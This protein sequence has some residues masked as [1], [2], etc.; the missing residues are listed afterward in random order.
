MST[1]KFDRF[2]GVNT[3]L[4]PN[5]LTVEDRNSRGRWLADAVNVDI[6]NDGSI[7][8][9][10][11]TERVA[12]VTAPH[13]MFQ[14]M[15]VRSGVLYRFA[16]PYA[17]TM[18]RLLSANDRMSYAKIG[19]QVFMSNGTDALRVD[20]N[21]DVVP[22]ALPAPA[23]PTVAAIDGEMSPGDYMVAIA[24]ANCEEVGCMSEAVVVDASQA[25]KG[26][27]RVTLPG[28]AEGATHIKVYISGNGGN[29]P[30]LHSTVEVGTP[31]LDI[32]TAPAGNEGSRQIEAPLPAGHRI[33]EHNGRLC[34]VSG[35]VLYIGQPYRHGYYLPLSGVIPFHDDISIAIGNQDGVY[36]AAG[37]KTYFIAGQD[38]EAGETA[39]R[40][41]FNFGAVPGTEFTH[42]E[43]PLVGWFSHKGVVIAAPGGEVSPMMENVDVTP[44]A[45]GVSVVLTDDR[46]DRVVS[47]GWAVNLGSGAA[48]RYT[49]FDFTSF[50]G[51][52][53]TSADGIH[54]IGALAEV[55]AS[56]DLGQEDF[57]TE[58][59]KRLPAIYLGASSG[60][61]L[62]VT[63]QASA[64]V[65]YEYRA[66][67]Y[68]ETLDIHRVDPGKGLRGN[69][70]RLVIKNGDGDD[71]K[72]ASVSFA[73]SASPRRI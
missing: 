21:G 53:A 28:G 47:C 4:P 73:P 16:L 66:R 37:G 1:I 23:A 44:P 3:R 57:G 72:L 18:L 64:G 49:G 26:G 54:E 30:M 38:I 63:A 36:V 31:S 10:I 71:F 60:F 29:V 22:W 9:R 70:F 61:P 58:Q 56:I 33:F 50:S 17:E 43:K 48:T 20:C 34:S 27:V 46:R 6:D 24:Y 55:S 45:S 5:S 25:L 32:V 2:L 8:R 59:E 62:V 19:D 11:G 52:F 51:A 67:S 68:S 35:K 7:L 14:D 40:D 15:L 13:S 65:E 39:V 69:W 12:E 41:V 42:P